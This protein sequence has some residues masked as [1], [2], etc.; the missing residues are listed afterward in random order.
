M[1][2]EGVLASAEQ[3]TARAA[4]G[5]T[6][7]VVGRGFAGHVAGEADPPGDGAFGLLVD[8]DLSRGAS[9]LPAGIQERVSA[10]TFT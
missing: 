1:R 10:A 8:H 2:A 6:P 4:A 5:A 7:P 9:G 3:Q